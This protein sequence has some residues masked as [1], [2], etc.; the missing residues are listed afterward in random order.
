MPNKTQPSSTSV[1]AFLATAA[2]PS[3]AADAQVLVELLARITGEL[4]VMWGPSMVGFGR[5]HY[6]Y[7]SGREGDSFRVGFSP[8]KAQLVVYLMPGYLFDDLHELLARLGPHKVG[9]ACLYVK[10]LSDVDLGVLEE[11]V[12]EGLKRLEAVYPST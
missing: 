2:S 7:E 1:D 6:V 9:K 11:L 8:R 10:R 5:Y 12:R 4:P 3:V